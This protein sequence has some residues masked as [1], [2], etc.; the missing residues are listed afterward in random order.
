MTLTRLS[1]GTVWIGELARLLWS[2]LQC[3]YKHMLT[4]HANHSGASA[5]T[6][7]VVGPFSSRR[8]SGGATAGRSAGHGRG[9][10]DH[11][12]P[13]S[14]LRAPELQTGGFPRSQPGAD[15]AGLHSAG[16]RR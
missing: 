6:F 4:T 1:T 15:G 5:L 14:L 8:W 3:G 7:A 12:P 2:R 11:C 16:Q 10:G 9:G 13:G